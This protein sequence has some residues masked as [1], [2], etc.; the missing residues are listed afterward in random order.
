[1]DKLKEYIQN[2]RSQFD[3]M[4]PANG[5]TE[6]FAARLSSQK[7]RP[8]RTFRIVAAISGIA[9]TFLAGLMLLPL[10]QADSNS[11]TLSPELAEVS[12]YYSVRLEQEIDK[13][14]HLVTYADKE[15]KNELLTDIMVMREES[16]EFLHQICASHMDESDSI[17][18][19]IHHYQSQIEA[20]QSTAAL[21]EDKILNA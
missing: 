11:C 1:M 15:T 8:K 7:K 3:D 13:I 12:G 20:L 14:Q 10:G 19:I 6:R 9:A 4:E 21:L 5:H 16:S 18:I 2:N 17:P